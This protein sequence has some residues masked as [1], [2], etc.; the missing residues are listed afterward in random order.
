[1]SI[2]QRSWAYPTRPLKQL[3][4]I[5]NLSV[6]KVG[7]THHPGGESRQGQAGVKS[8]ELGVSTAGFEIKFHLPVV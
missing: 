4:I 3:E 2:Y 5:P 1:M 8:M 6:P 7:R